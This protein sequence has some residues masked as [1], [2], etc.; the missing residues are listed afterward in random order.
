MGWHR[1]FEFRPEQ[2]AGK[3]DSGHEGAHAIKLR[4]RTCQQREL[5]PVVL[6][7]IANR[8]TQKIPHL[9]SGNHHRNASGEPQ[10]DRLRYVLDESTQAH[11]GHKNQQ[12]TGHQGGQQQTTQT[13]ALGDRIEND[14]EGGRRPGDTE[15]AA[16][17]QCDHKS[18][19][20]GGIEPVLR[21]NTTGNRQCHG[22]WYGNNAH[23]YTGHQIP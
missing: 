22:Q 23:R 2:H 20:N 11:Q 10:G 9:Q 14:N 12:N 7:H 18:G 15:P 6:G 17:G 13:I 16:T 1:G 21:R 4:Q 5:V 19:N 8:Q 3:G